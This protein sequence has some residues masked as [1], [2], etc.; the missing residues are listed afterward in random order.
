MSNKIYPKYSAS[1]IAASFPLGSIRPCNKSQTE[2]MSPGFSSAV[3]PDVSA[4]YS[5]I[6]IIS[7]L[8]SILNRSIRLRTTKHVIILVKL[9]ISRLSLSNFP[10]SIYSV[11]ESYMIQLCA[12]INGCGISSSS[13]VSWMSLIFSSSFSYVTRVALAPI[14]APLPS[15]DLS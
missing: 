2:R 14:P 10:N 15:T 6:S 12:L 4:A 7:F 13:F 9:A 5:E 11:F 1:Y 8:S 3:V